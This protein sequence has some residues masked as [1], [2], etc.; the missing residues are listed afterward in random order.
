MSELI[1]TPS[2]TVGP[3]YSTGLLWEGSTVAALAGDAGT[4]E[5]RGVLSD[6]HGP[7]VY[8]EGVIEMWSG[9]QF[10][11][12]QTDAQGSY[13]VVLRGPF[14][15]MPLADGRSQAPH[16]N[17]A[18]FGRG[19]LKPLHTR[20]YF[21]HNEAEN[22]AD[23]VLGLVPPDRR[24]WLIAAAESDGRVRFDICVQGPN[25]GVFFVL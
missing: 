2:Q 10:A 23:P 18:L 7:F 17:V 11:R 22:A 19:L 15:A 6:G 5:I 12:A 14:D 8:P 16:L 9:D 21:P 4:I 24:R 25:E 20:M 13:V 3:F 1:Y